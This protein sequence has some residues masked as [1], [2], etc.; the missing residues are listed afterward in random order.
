[1]EETIRS[2]RSAGSSDISTWP[3]FDKVTDDRSVEFNK[4]A[5]KPD[6]ILLEGWLIGALADPEAPGSEAANN[7]EQVED[8]LGA[9]RRWQEQALAKSYE[10]LWQMFDDFLYLCAPSFETVYDWRCEQ[11]E[12]T[13]ALL[14]GSLSREKREWVAHFIQHYERI[15][16]RILAGH[17]MPGTRIPINANRLASD[18]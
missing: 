18:S 1:M 5:G 11:E 10:P 13:L 2:L 3:K 16:R 14:K 7:L 4:F 17:H 8:P 12:T 6:A 15:T 9:W